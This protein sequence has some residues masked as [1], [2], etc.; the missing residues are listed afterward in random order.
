[1]PSKAVILWA[2]DSDDDAL[3]MQRAFNKAQFSTILMRVQDGCEATSYLLGDGRY[4]DRSQFPL[5]N[6][7]LLDIKMPRMSGFEVLAWKQTR[8]EFQSLPTVILSSS[9]QEEDIKEAY[10]LGAQQYLM[11]PA[12]VE[13]LVEHVKELHK[14]WSN[15]LS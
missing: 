4:G 5:P 14:R 2:E 15:E 8:P 13:E 1:M 10:R 7:L 9:I 11:K 12:K 6:L 3:L